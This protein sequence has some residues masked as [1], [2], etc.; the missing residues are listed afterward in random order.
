MCGRICHKKVDFVQRSRKIVSDFL[1]RGYSKRKVATVVKRFLKRVPL[2]FPIEKLG[3]F[4]KALFAIGS[5][6]TVP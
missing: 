4:T 5:E 6:R 2:E 1:N 3:S